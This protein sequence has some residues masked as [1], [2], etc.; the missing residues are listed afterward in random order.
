MTLSGADFVHRLSL[1]VL[2]RGFTKIRHYGLLGNNRRQRTVP[3]ARAALARSR[4]LLALALHAARPRARHPNT[5]AAGR[6][7][8]RASPGSILPA[9][10]SRSPPVPGARGSAPATRR[11][12]ATPP[13]MIVGF[14]ISAVAP[15]PFRAPPKALREVH[16][17]VREFG[18]PAA[19]KSLPRRPLRLLGPLP[20][21]PGAARARSAAGGS[22]GL[23]PFGGPGRT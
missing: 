20:G 1:H 16:A 15:C 12:C 4:W 7:I 3:L 5:P 18:S 10:S 19:D 2:P 22:S 6:T 13:D 8:S 11:R 21:T 14:L 23:P 17:P 9:N